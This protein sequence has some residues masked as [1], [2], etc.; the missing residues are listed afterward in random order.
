LLD[1]P[2]WPG[3]RQ[4][5]DSAATSGWSL[6]LD[7]LPLV[8]V[9]SALVSGVIGAGIGSLTT[10]TVAWF[11]LRSQATRE[12]HGRVIEAASQCLLAHSEFFAVSDNPKNVDVAS[13]VKRAWMEPA[14][15]HSVLISLLATRRGWRR[16]ADL[17]DSLHDDLYEAQLEIARVS[18]PADKAVAFDLAFRAYQGAIVRWLANARALRGDLQEEKAQLVVAARRWQ[19]EE[20]AIQ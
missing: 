15:R 16:F 17:A 6:A 9:D 13:F 20:Q 5:R 1:L 7:P 19:Q 11:T 4:R 8:G 14:T 10:G 2:L 12:L 3:E 18:P